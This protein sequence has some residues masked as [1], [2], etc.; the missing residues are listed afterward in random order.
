MKILIVLPTQLFQIKYI[1]NTKNKF[2]KIIIWEHPHYFTKYN[3]NKKKII[4][5]RASMKYYLDYLSKRKYSVEYYDFNQEFKINHDE[6]QLYIFDPIDKIDFNFK[7][8]ILESPN[9]LLTKQDYLEYRNKTKNFTF[10]NGF[11]TWSKKKINIIPNIKSQDKE[12]RKR[13]PKNIEI[14]EIPKLNSDQEYIN[15]AI[16]FV[17]KF[18]SHNYG[19]CD[20]FIFPIS[21]ENANKWKNNFYQQR[22]NNFGPYEDFIYHKDPYLFHS[23][24]SSSLNIG[25]LNPIEIIDDL[26]PK[27]EDY[28]LNSYEGYIRQ[29]FWREYQRYC[30]IYADF[31]GNYFKSKK[32]L[33]HNW[34][35]GTTGIDPID[36]YIKIA[37]NNAYLHHICRL[38]LIGNFMLLN[39]INPHEGF[40]WFMEFSIDSYEWVMNQNVLDM[41]FFVTGGLTMKKPYISTSNYIIKMSTYKKGDWSEKWDIICNKFLLKN[42]H[43]L[44]DNPRFKYYFSNWKVYKN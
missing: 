33:N 43:L 9:F 6:D 10:T 26:R 42:K 24:L 28:D 7:L 37:F 44:I 41:V 11:Y 13:M 36:D 19:N 21:F 1:K 18:F 30:F 31:S 23:V 20:N 27:Q 38:M 14:P 16:D 40:R 29:L 34:Y 8:N 25:L 22:L 12:N 2:N 15:E 3:Y 4:L 39:E 5:H 32:K 17:N 35:S